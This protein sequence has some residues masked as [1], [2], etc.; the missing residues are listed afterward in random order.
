MNNFFDYNNI[1]E[2]QIEVTTYCNA[3]C[4]QCPRNINGAG[5]NP[6]LTLNHLP[7]SVIDQ[8]FS[9]EI[10]SR[11]RQIFFCGSYGDPIMHPNFLEILKDFRSKNPTLWLYIHTNGGVHNVDYWE[12]IA[13]ILNGYGQID[14]GIDGLEDT[15]HLYRKNV[16]Y[17]KV[18]ENASAFINAG[19]RAQWNFIIFRHNEHQ[20][21]DAQQVAKQL[22]FFNFLPR[23]T[24][25]F[26][27]HKTVEEMPYWPVNGEDYV[28]EPPTNSKYKNNSMLFLP[29][30]KKQ[31]QNLQ[32]Y[33][34]TTEIKC[35]AAIGKKVTIN[36][37]GLVLP[38]NFFNHNL[39]DA[40]FFN[41]E[42][43]GANLLSYVDHGKN[44]VRDFLEKYGLENLNIKNNS[45][46]EIFNNQMW[47]DLS[48]SWSKNLRN[49]RLF[50][51]A[52]TCGS[53]LQKVWDQGGSKR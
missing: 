11:T 2:Y 5:L 4:P 42:L 8:T 16:K 27:N 20:V 39:Y 51:C 28:L 10:C 46:E 43:P 9:K 15:L 37:Q 53:K 47:T 26:F 17:K 35:D 31:Y 52:M 50:E 25:R 13:K 48:N 32:E 29:N 19:G 33:F 1:D 21:N 23:N 12:S 40:R 24:G 49:G 45:L 30:L 3:A 44:Q 18:I 22:G 38:C 34:S 6:Y 41:D 14:F 36:A 7:Q